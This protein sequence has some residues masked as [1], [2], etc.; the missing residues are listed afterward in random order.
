MSQGNLDTLSSQ[1][2]TVINSDLLY[3]YIYIYILFMYNIHNNN[4]II[5]MTLKS[6]CFLNRVMTFVALVIANFM[7]GTA[8]KAEELETLVK[9]TKSLVRQFKC[10]QGFILLSSWKVGC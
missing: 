9:N 3:I 2:T 7:V 4:T 8:I 1:T 6:F 5:Q 10:F